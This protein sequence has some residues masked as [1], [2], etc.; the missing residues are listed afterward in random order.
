M[1]V[2]K[3]RVQSKPEP[4]QSRPSEQDWKIF[5]MRLEALE[6]RIVPG[7]PSGHE[8]LDL[9]RQE[10]MDTRH[11]LYR[12]NAS[13]DHLRKAFEAQAQAQGLLMDAMEAQARASDHLQAADREREQAVAPFVI[14]PDP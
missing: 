11:A 6:A 12:T 7:V 14:R 1:R 5:V 9:L 13:T 2:M 8:E 10:L 3:R 4:A